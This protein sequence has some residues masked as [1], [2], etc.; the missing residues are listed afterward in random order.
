MLLPQPLRNISFEGFVGVPIYLICRNA[1]KVANS[2]VYLRKIFAVPVSGDQTLDL[3]IRAY[4][5]KS[6]GVSD[7][8][9]KAQS[10]DFTIENNKM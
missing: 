1:K 10:L 3:S 7:V 6:L 5:V 8:R 2:T 9:E 4:A